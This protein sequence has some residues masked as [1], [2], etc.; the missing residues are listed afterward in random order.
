MEFLRKAGRLV[1]FGPVGVAEA[2]ADAA[3]VFVDGAV[4]VGKGYVQRKLRQSM[5]VQV[6]AALTCGKNNGGDGC[7]GGVFCICRENLQLHRR[8]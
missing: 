6:Q 3:D 1:A 4:F 2:R 8:A 7:R 5:L